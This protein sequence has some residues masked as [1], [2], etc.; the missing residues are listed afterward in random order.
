M[1]IMDFNCTAKDSGTYSNSHLAGLY[2]TFYQSL[3]LGAFYSIIKNLPDDCCVVTGHY[4]SN[5]T[6]YTVRHMADGR[7]SLSTVESATYTTSDDFWGVHK[8]SDFP[9]TYQTEYALY[10]GPRQIY[11]FR[12]YAHAA[13]YATSKS[14]DTCYLAGFDGEKVLFDVVAS[15]TGEVKETISSTTSIFYYSISH[16]TSRTKYYPKTVEFF[17]YHRINPLPPSAEISYPMGIEM[18]GF[19]LSLKLRNAIRASKKEPAKA[20]YYL[21]NGVK[22]PA[23]PDWDEKAYPY[24]YILN[25]SGSQ[26]FLVLSIPFEYGTITASYDGVTTTITGMY[27]YA[28]AYTTGKAFGYMLREDSWVTVGADTWGGE[29]IGIYYGFWDTTAEAVWAN[30]NINNVDSG[31]VYLA[32]SNPVPV[33]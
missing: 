1:A 9:I 22:L 14:V 30:T 12:D 2:K 27:S 18:L 21:Y 5:N 25:L 13:A 10:A 26:L 32:A 20:A 29:E 24:A 33:A 8:C 3:D 7:Y 16:T 23:P 31:T 6:F 11:V 17:N 15:G 28:P 19:T 4:Y